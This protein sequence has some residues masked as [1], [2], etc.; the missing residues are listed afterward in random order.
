ME[1]PNMTNGISEAAG[2]KFFWILISAAAVG[3]M[4]GVGSFITVMINVASLKAN[5]DNMQSMLTE[6][7]NDLK[8][9]TQNRYTSDQ[10]ATDRATTQGEIN[11]IRETTMNVMIKNN[12]G[13][14]T[15]ITK[16]L[17]LL[18][19]QQKEIVELE[20]FKAKA[21]EK[22]RLVGDKQ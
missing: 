17:E 18:A 3:L 5:S 6:V 4:G 8:M 13:L 9:A 10:A 22:L 19:Q 16:C 2:S 14:N 7:R 21:D 1:I 12:E 15:Q 20:L 11:S